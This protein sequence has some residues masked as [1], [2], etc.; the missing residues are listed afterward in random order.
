MESR[1]PTNGAPAAKAELLPP[2]EVPVPFLAA[3]ETESFVLELGK[4]VFLVVST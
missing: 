2:L 1:P 4:V 3:P